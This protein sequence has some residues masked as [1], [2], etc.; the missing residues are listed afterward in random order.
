MAYII[1][2]CP[3]CY[4]RLVKNNVYPLNDKLCFH[5]CQKKK[6]SNDLSPLHLCAARLV[7]SNEPL[8]DVHKEVRGELGKLVALFVSVIL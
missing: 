8:C 2:Q 3:I 1:Q 6:S 4:V 7:G 5:L